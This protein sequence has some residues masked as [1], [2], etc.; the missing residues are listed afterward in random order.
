MNR[1][2]ETNWEKLDLA[3]QLLYVAVCELVVFPILTIPYRLTGREFRFGVF[4][5]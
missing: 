1:R 3:M 5:L 2:R 4:L